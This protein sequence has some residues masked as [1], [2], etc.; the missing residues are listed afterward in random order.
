MKIL[1]AEELKKEVQEP[2]QASTDDVS[3]KESKSSRD[4]NEIFLENLEIQNNKLKQYNELQIE[5][6]AYIKGILWASTMLCW[7]MIYGI[8]SGILNFEK[9]PNF[10][11]VV[12]GSFFVQ[13]IGLA[14]IVTKHLF[15]QEELKKTDL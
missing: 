15:P 12:V 11:H 3:N 8:G 2:I 9:Y 14:Y 6:S 10:P 13:V 1:K 4:C 5:W 7:L